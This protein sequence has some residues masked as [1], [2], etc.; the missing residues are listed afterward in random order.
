MN[1]RFKKG[2]LELCTLALFSKKDYYGYELVHAISS[3]IEIAGGTVYAFQRRVSKVGYSETYIK[4]S[5]EGPAREYHRITRK[6]KTYT[7]ALTGE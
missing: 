7:E 5:D 2:V 4:E 6:G 3:H 1:I